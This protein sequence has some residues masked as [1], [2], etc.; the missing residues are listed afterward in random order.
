MVSQ[1]NNSYAQIVEEEEIHIH[2]VP[3]YRL[4]LHTIFFFG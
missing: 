3:G 2:P 4:Y 1:S